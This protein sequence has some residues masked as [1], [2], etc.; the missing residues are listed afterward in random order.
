MEPKWKQESKI[1]ASFK[2]NHIILSPN[3]AIS[4]TLDLELLS[5]LCCGFNSSIILGANSWFVEVGVVS[6]YESSENYFWI[7]EFS[8]WDVNIL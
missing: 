8:F 5:C 4:Y 1:Q 7:R 2:K 3:S 6:L